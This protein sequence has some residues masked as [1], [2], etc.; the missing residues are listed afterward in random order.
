MWKCAITVMKGQKN[1]NADTDESSN[2]FMRR[3]TE[4]ILASVVSLPSGF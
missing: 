1:L 4:P 2:F 3:A